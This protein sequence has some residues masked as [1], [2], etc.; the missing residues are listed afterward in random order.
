MVIFW[1]VHVKE[2]VIGKIF[3]KLGNSII[4]FLDKIHHL[5]LMAAKRL[6]KLRQNPFSINSA[7][8]MNFSSVILTDQ[9]IRLLA[10][11]IC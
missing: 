11:L 3:W 4:C 9:H 7:Q 6:F 8:G 5:I 2:N 10:K 1:R